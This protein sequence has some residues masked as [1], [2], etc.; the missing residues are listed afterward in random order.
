MKRKICRVLYELIGKHLPR[1]C[2]FGGKFSR[3]IRYAL[4]SRF[5]NHCGESV[6]FEHGAT[7]S[8]KVS[9]GNH[10]GIGV[11]ADIPAEV[12]IGDYVVMGPNCKIYT[13]NHKHEFNET[14]FL[15]QGYEEVKPVVIGNNVWIGGSVTI[16]PGKT[17]G[18]NVV[19]GACSV[20]TNNVPDNCIVGGNPAKIIKKREE[21]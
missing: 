20:V 2:H 3:K 5:I 17:I 13:Q 1:Q 7:I 9:I 4:V 18:N 6:N 16:L 11:N 10:S 21:I 15:Q 19:I 14:P 12:T 8:S